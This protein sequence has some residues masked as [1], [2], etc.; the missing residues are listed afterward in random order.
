MQSIITEYC[1]CNTVLLYVCRLLK[2]VNLKIIAH[3]LQSTGSQ[4]LC[5]CITTLQLVELR[6]WPYF[7]SIIVLL[8]TKDE[9]CVSITSCN[10]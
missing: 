10:T 4:L 3:T 8:Y 7:Y 1:P 5:V 9:I 2:I 6:S